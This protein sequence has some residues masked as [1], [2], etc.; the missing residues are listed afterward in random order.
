MQ[1]VIDISDNKYKYIKGL[2]DEIT[3]YQTSLMLYKAV[4]NGTVLPKHGR[5]IDADDIDNIT[6]VHNTKDVLVRLEAP[7]ILEAWGNEE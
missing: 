7:T 5:L 4:K 1:I 6:V 3:D 2:D